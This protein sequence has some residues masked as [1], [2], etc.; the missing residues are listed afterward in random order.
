MI[1]NHMLR[2]GALFLLTVLSYG[3][4]NAYL[5]ITDPVESNYVLSAITML[6]HNSWISPMIYDTYWALMI[7]YK[8]FG[9]SDFTSRI[10]NTLIAGGSVALM[11]HLVYRIKESKHIAVMSALL[12]FSALQF[13]YI[14]HA[15]ITDG[16]LFF[17][18][19][20]I[21]GY[22]YLAFAKN[23]KYSMV[24]AYGAASLAVVTK[25][26]V[27]IVLPGL[28]LLLFIAI[29]WFTKKDMD[30]YSLD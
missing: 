29:R 16:F 5:P 21:F 26:P 4:Y 11:Y 2:I 7:S 27:G 18:S 28:I 22:S 17:F 14:S 25:G 20:A 10:P 24:K 30:E 6:K 15:V 8:L 1:N 3:F 12:L 13:W 19:L 9:I 23:D